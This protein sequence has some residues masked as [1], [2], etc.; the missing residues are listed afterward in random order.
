MSC[1]KSDC[2]G[3]TGRR[4]RGKPLSSIKWSNA[5]QTGHKGIDREHRELLDTVTAI[6]AELTACH[7][8]KSNVD[9]IALRERMRSHFQAEERLLADAV[10]PRLREHVS[11]HEAALRKVKTMI[12]ECCEDCGNGLK[13]ECIRRW[14]EAILDD[15]L[16]ADLDFKSYLQYKNIV[17]KD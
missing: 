17:P 3:R 16:L 13:I 15:V 8:Q 5:Y 11:T 10:F 2:C 12:G 1:K 6:E 7:F 4:I 9:C 14:C